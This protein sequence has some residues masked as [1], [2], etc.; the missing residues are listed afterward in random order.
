M[1]TGNAN[2]HEES[3]G[4]ARQSPVLVEQTQLDVGEVR[5][6]LEGPDGRHRGLRRQHPVA[7]PLDVGHGDGLIQPKWLT[8]QSGIHLTKLKLRPDLSVGYSQ[9]FH[10]SVNNF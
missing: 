6:V 10:S 4:L 1:S 7:H 8:F 3:P 2:S 9:K 5:E